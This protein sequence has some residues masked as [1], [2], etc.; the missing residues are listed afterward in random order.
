MNDHGL[1]KSPSRKIGDGGK[2]RKQ[3]SAKEMIEIYRKNQKNVHKFL[4][5]RTLK[6]LSKM[7]EIK[8][9]FL[10]H[11]FPEKLTEYIQLKKDCERVF[12]F[13]MVCASNDIENG[14]EENLRQ[15]RQ[16]LKDIVRK[17]KIRS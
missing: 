13:K 1:N 9:S 10:W 2:T 11:V 17:H 8:S 7:K 12:K 16:V 14:F 4:E 3:Y 5:K 6:K 15:R